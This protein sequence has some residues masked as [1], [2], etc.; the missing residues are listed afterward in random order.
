ME[1]NGTSNPMLT[2]CNLV[3]NRARFGGGMGNDYSSSPALTNCSFVGNTASDT[4][5]GMFNTTT[6][7]PTLV[8]CSFLGNSSVNNGGGIY[9]QNSNPSLTNCVLFG[10]GGA[11][12]ISTDRSVS[13]TYSLLEPAVTGYTSSPTNLITT[14]SPFISATDASLN[15][16]SPAINAGLNSA[17]STAI[18]LAG[19]PRVYRNGR[20]DMGAYE[21]HAAPTL[22]TLTAPSVNTATVGVAFSQTFTASGAAPG[23]RTVP[24]ATVWPAVVCPRV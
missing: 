22:I 3:E 18:D 10:N 14:F 24:T 5:G 16:C 12:T 2:N 15:D 9:N 11:N 4:G 17:N 19:N 20:I 1:N 7:N 21:Y 6:S 13:V 8:N 23:R